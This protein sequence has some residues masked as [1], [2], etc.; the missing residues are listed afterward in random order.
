LSHVMGWHVFSYPVTLVLDKNDSTVLTNPPF[1]T[2]SDNAGIDLQF[3]RTATR[4]ARRSVYSFHKRSTRAFLLKTIQED[5]GYPDSKVVAEMAFDVPKMYKFHTQKS[6]DIEVDLIRIVVAGDDDVNANSE[7]QVD[8]PRHDG[9]LPSSD[10]E[11]S[12]PT[13]LF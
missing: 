1:G 5:W 10:N 12:E 2:K 4:L 13:A 7:H 6:K 8:G 11:D 3:L 9:E